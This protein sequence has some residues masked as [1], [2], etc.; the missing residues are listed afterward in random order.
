MYILKF[1]KFWKL[2]LRYL[3][4]IQSSFPKV[5]FSKQ[6]QTTIVLRDFDIE[7]ITVY[8]Y[9]SMC[10]CKVV[11]QISANHPLSDWVWVGESTKIR[12][13]SCMCPTHVLFSS[14][15]LIP[16]V[17]PGMMS[18]CIKELALKTPSV[19]SKSN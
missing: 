5:M 6:T 14:L 15:S 16:R 12:W 11:N 13:S 17:F 4:F 18:E 19:T 8:L 7:W 2:H 1:W 3:K 10:T 9:L